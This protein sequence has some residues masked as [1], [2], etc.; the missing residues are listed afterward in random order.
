LNK[1][2]GEHQ[3]WVLMIM[4]MSGNGAQPQMTHSISGFNS[5][6]S[7]AIAADTIKSRQQNT[8]TICIKL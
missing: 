1:Q 8:K 3:M 5:E 6:L 4:F 7:C 2:Q